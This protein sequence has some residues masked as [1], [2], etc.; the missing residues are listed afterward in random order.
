MTNNFIEQF[1]RLMKG[2]GDNERLRSSE[3]DYMA[4][5]CEDIRSQKDR[6]GGNWAVAS[7]VRTREERDLM[8]RL[9]GPEL[10]LVCLEMSSEERHKR[11]LARHG[12]ESSATDLVDVSHC[13]FLSNY[14]CH[15][16]LLLFSFSISSS[17]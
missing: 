6:L 11:I 4:A 17:S 2:G 8:R 3:R 12:G 16:I 13:D 7:V 1:W 5:M 15:V 14:Y 10:T 9:L